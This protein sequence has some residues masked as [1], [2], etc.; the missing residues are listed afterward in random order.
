MMDFLT[1]ITNPAFNTAELKLA[2]LLSQ[3]QVNETKK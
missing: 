2:I 3:L 1:L